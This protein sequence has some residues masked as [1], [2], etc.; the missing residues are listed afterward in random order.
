MA[1]DPPR[2]LP[3]VPTFLVPSNID[4]ENAVVENLARPQECGGGSEVRTVTSL[5]GKEA[6]TLRESFRRR[7]LPE[8]EG[9]I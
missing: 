1:V 5:E 3:A 9:P 6:E 4:R 8:C 7:R 2:D